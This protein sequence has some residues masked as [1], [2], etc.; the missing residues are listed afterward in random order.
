MAYRW[1]S[2]PRVHQHNA[3]SP[4]GSSRTGCCLFRYHYGPMNARLFPPTNSIIGHVVDMFD[5]ANIGGMFNDVEH[6]GIPQTASDCIT[7]S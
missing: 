1:R 2:L 5:T 6:F 4:Q 3:N 7:L